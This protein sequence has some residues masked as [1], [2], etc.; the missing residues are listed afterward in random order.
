MAMRMRVCAVHEG[1]AHICKY[2]D[3]DENLIHI[4]HIKISMKSVTFYD[5][6]R[7]VVLLVVGAI[8]WMGISR[9]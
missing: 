9:W 1:Y 3:A 5:G 6:C 8:H 2:E 7:A 4:I